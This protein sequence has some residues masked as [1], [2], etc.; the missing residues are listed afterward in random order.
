VALLAGRQAAV[1]A[2]AVGAVGAAGTPIDS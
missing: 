1:L 2:G